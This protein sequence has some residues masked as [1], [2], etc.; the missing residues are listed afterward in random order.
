MRTAAS[1][2]V[3]AP[4]AALKGRTAALAGASAGMYGETLCNYGVLMVKRLSNGGSFDGALVFPGG[5]HEPED[6]G[7]ADSHGACAVRE[8]FEETGLLL[9]TGGAAH[10]GALSFG[11]ICS[12]HG[13]AP[14]SVQPLARWTTPRAQKKRF[15]T[16]FVMLNVG[17]GDGWLLDQLGRERVQ[18]SELSSLDWIA[19]DQAMRANRTELP[20]FPPQAYILHELST[21]RRWQDLAQ[22]MAARFVGAEGS[23]EPLLCRRSDSKVVALFPGDYAYPDMRVNE[24]SPQLRVS[25]GDL[26]CREPHAPGLHRMEMDSAAKGGF[27]AANLI[28]TV[29][30]GLS[31]L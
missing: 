11:E 5:V 9:T 10:A 6:L 14:L 8:T 18:A 21:V 15:D 16:R 29:A 19:P 13:I 27:L 4:L 3:T 22:S 12:G 7:F 24:H 2:I 1:L 20:L 17:D 28:R 30:S 25:D 26:F 23:M 31:R